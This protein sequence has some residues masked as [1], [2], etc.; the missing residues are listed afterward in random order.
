MNSNPY[1]IY[2]PFLDE[3]LNIKVLSPEEEMNLSTKFY[4][5]LSKYSR[6]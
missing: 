4:N 3:V 2:C 1:R 5:K 6:L